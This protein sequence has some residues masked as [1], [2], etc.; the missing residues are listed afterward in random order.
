MHSRYSQ[1]IW[2]LENHEFGGICTR[3]N[4]HAH[5]LSN[6]PLILGELWQDVEFCGSPSLVSPAVL[7]SLATKPTLTKTHH[8]CN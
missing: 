5:I 4:L 6:G 8:A 2:H 7:C 1:Y 3:E